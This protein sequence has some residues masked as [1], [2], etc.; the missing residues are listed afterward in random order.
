MMYRT[1]HHKQVSI[2]EWQ[3]EC[4]PVDASGS[5]HS[6]KGPNQLVDAKPI[7]KSLILIIQ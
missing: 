5:T 2:L 1:S 7:D 4:I 3:H 6:A